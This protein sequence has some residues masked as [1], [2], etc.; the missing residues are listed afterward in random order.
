MIGI[1][2]QLYGQINNYYIG[3]DIGLNLDVNQVVS[4]DNNYFSCWTNCWS[5]KD[6]FYQRNG[7]FSLSAGVELSN[8]MIYELM[9]TKQTLNFTSQYLLPVE[10]TS[11]VVGGGGY[12]ASA[13]HFKWT[14]GTGR[15][16]GLGKRFY[17]IPVLQASYMYV[18]NDITSIFV[19]EETYQTYT[20]KESLRNLNEN[21]FFIGIKNTLQW[22]A[23]NRWSINLQFGY[24]QG[25][26]KNYELKQ[27]IQF[28]STPDD[29]SK[30]HTISRLS[31]AFASL[32]TSY[33]FKMN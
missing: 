1:Q 4:N 26:L 12:A 25:L 28:E 14:A 31:H 24:T 5:E 30:G 6:D 3:V 22:K 33:I 17:Y 23:S 20:Y 11:D 10:I 8:K 15:R 9:F 27:E 2:S 18:E 29:I 21:Q 16:I 13:P 19:I 32:G 7:I